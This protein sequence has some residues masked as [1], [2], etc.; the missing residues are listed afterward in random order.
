MVLSACTSII[1]SCNS[2]VPSSKPPQ[3]QNL[4]WL[5]DFRHYLDGVDSAILSLAEAAGCYENKEKCQESGVKGIFFL[6]NLLYLYT[7]SIH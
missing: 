6:I 7:E 3:L 1:Q 2:L 4:F 5:A